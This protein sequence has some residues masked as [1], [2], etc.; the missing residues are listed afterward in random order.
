MAAV[1]AAVVA[2]VATAASAGYSAY[3]ASQAG[4]GGGGNPQFRQAPA[5]P[6]DRAMRSYYARATLANATKTYPSFGA[7][8]SSGGDPSLAKFDLDMPD[9]KPSEAAAFGFTGGRGES[10]PGAGYAG[11]ASGDVKN[12]SPDQILFLAKERRRQAVATGQPVGGWA[13]SV[14]STDRQLRSVQARKSALE[15]LDPNTLTPHQEHKLQKLGRRE[16]R[17]TSRQT[18]QLN[19]G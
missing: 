8:A 1:T 4:G 15:Q 16:E 18:G 17:L 12:L 2:G 19:P 5:D 14:L 9:L 3:S 11:L 13:H 6:L 10:I 7:Y